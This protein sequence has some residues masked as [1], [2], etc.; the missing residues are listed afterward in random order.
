MTKT[1]R[2]FHLAFPVTSITKTIDWY[3]KT[4]KI[5]GKINHDI[6]LENN[7][8]EKSDIENQ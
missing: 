6:L 3:V 4:H 2:P 5:E 8:S 1:I 7:P